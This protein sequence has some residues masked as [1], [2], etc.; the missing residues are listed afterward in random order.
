LPSYMISGLFIIWALEAAVVVPKDAARA[1][2]EG[3]GAQPGAHKGAQPGRAQ[4]LVMVALAGILAVTIIFQFQFIPRNVPYGQLTTWMD[5]G[6][7]WGIHTT[8]SRKAFL[9]TASADLK[10]VLRPG[11][12]LM[13]MYQVPGLYLYWPGPVASNSVWISRADEN[14]P[15]PQP[16]LDWLQ[17]NRQV[18]DVIFREIITGARAPAELARGYCGGFAYD[19]VVVRPHYMLLRRPAGATT[20]QILAGREARAAQAGPAQ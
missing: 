13:V 16:T 8:V 5:R 2:D 18:P 7:Y 12:K 19:V 17:R 14:G 6:P 10:A 20:A 4:A 11:D 3:V 1:D 9:T 15:L